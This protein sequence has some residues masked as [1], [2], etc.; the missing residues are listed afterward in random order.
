VQPDKNFD[1]VMRSVPVPAG[2][3]GEMLSFTPEEA[4]WETLGFSA[5]RLAPG[6]TWKRTTADHEAILVVLGGKL[7]IDW[8]EGPQSMGHRDNVFLGYPFAAY[9][10]CGLSYEVCAESVVEFA[11]TR[12]RSQRPSKPRII[13]PAEVG[14]EIRGGGNSTRQILRILR[15][16]A[17]ADKLMAN[18]VFTPDGNWSSYPP[19]KHDTLNLPTECDLDEIYYFRVDHPDGFGFLRV[20]DAEGKHDSTA[21]IH[22]GDLGLLR[23]GYHLVAAPP[24][25]KVYYLAVLA[26][27]ARNLA[28]ATD[29]S[30]DHMKGK[31]GPLDPRVPMILNN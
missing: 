14:N 30:Y 7:T 17:D 2:R 15:P 6:D 23:S 19:H 1:F 24:G 21:L 31:A 26:G 11:E 5:Q 29:P 4:G 25:Y 22:D 10:P 8:G 27:A 9:L 28:A 3:S 18:E 16:E 20:Y 13:T 12:V